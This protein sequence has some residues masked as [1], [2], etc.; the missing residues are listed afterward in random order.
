VE[1]KIIRQRREDKIQADHKEN[2]VNSWIIYIQ[3][4]T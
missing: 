2:K 4:R 1:V 3:Q